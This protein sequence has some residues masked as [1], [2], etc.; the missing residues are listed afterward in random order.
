MKVYLIHTYHIVQVKIQYAIKTLVRLQYPYS[1]FT[2]APYPCGKRSTL[3]TMAA[4]EGMFMR[5][6]A[7]K[8]TV[9]IDIDP[10]Y[11]IYPD[12]RYSGYG[13]NTN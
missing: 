6:S 10:G 11:G 12:Y 8:V 4:T 9:L 13:I 5:S 3:A 7:S 2:L 1:T